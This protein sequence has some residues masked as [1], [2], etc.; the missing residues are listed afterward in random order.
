MD[1]QEQPVPSDE[2]VL[3]LPESWL[4][5]VHPRRGGVMVAPVNPADP[6]AARRILADAADRVRALVEEEPAHPER[7]AAARRHLAG[8]PDPA[9]AAALASAAT[10]DRGDRTDACRVFVDGWA[11]EHG[12][13][14]AAR[15]ALELCRIDLTDDESLSLSG[16]RIRPSP[17]ATALGVLRRVRVL[18]VE[19]DDAVY[20]EAAE[21][22]EALRWEDDQVVQ[23][24][25][26]IAYLFPTRQDRIDELLGG[27]V[28]WGP[29]EDL[30]RCSLGRPAQLDHCRGRYYRERLPVDVLATM[31]DGLGADLAPWLVH[32]LDHERVGTETVG[33][34]F[35]A[36]ALLP[37]D[38][39]VGALLD[40][41][42]DRRARA[43]LAEA[44]RRF[45]VRTVRVLARS[46]SREAAGLL[47][48]HVRANPGLVTA[49]ADLPDDVRAAVEPIVR[50]AARSV[51]EA[52]PEEL[53]AC[54]ASPPWKR[55]VK[56]AA[57]DLAAPE[58]RI[59]W[60]A[61][62]RAEWLAADTSE[63][64][65]L[66][67]DWAELARR[68]NDFGAEKARFNVLL[69]GPEDLARPILARWN[70][71]ANH[72]DSG[73]WRKVLVARFGLD[74]HGFV[75]WLVSRN[76]QRYP[77]LILPFLSAGVAAVVSERLAGRGPGCE[78]ARAWL[79]LHGTAAV[80]YL[81]PAVLSGAVKERRA[82][83]TALRHIAGRHGVD[84]VAAACPAAPDELRTLL[85]AHPA[86]TGLV[87]PPRIG[88]WVERAGFPQVLYR[89]GERAL[90]AADVP[91]LL[92]LLALPVPY[93]TGELRATFEPA[94]IAEL[95]W[96]AFTHWN[97][98]GRPSKEKWALTQL[99]SSGDDE[100][101]RR[102][103]P[104]IRAWPGEGGHRYAVTGLD[105]LAAIGSDVALMHLHSI[106]QKVKFKG[107]RARA[108]EKIAEVAEA[109]G[110]SLDELA[111]RLVP[112]FGLAADGSMTLD[113]GP[114]RFTVGFDEQLKPFVVAESGKLRKALPKPG[115]KDDPELAPAA[116][117][118]FA[119]LKKDVRAVAADQLR[120]LER[121]MATSRRWTPDEFRT[122]LVAHPLVGRVTR[123]LVW[124]AEDDGGAAAFR[125]AE[126]GTFADVDDETFVLP[127]TVR[128][129]IAH[130]LHLGDSLGAW[131]EV[132]ADY[133]LLQPFEQ[134]ARP[135]HAL[136]EEELGS[137]RLERFEGLK[138]PYGTALGL[139]KRGWERAE[140]GEAGSQ[141]YMSRRVAA[142]RYVVIDL[143][144][145][146]S[147]GDP[148]ATGDVQ[149][150]EYVRL[151]AEPGMFRWSR[152]AGHP[153]GELDPVTASEIV[154]DLTVLRDAAL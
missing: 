152:S 60:P 153:F 148:G 149:T 36:L 38:E 138:V 29:L 128:V 10:R 12:P 118:A 56:P 17:D 69:Y 45:P 27:D 121:A 81:A 64:E 39:A 134:L 2:D 34:V 145:G 94:S 86:Q 154:A 24:S 31:M 130:P 141:E 146:F 127:E 91:R 116:Y 16:K 84:A 68:A 51:P 87:K 99:G 140:P 62:M 103:A 80:E 50:A 96:S 41:S 115:A 53:P 33:R 75:S 28:T 132:F 82:A 144:P 14:F 26:M 109:R 54:M 42:A 7:A 90:P 122:H 88:D 40:R 65:R 3:R 9:G 76:L 136:T 107:L 15:A 79:D 112:R 35:D 47:E 100:A 123:R 143:D 43:A 117:K 108:Q 67:P 83:E 126:D 85:A 32:V 110:L 21:R 135:V 72:Y 73:E 70:G 61:G 11:A 59:V 1:D 46:G 13:V 111:D 150:V 147:V 125:V 78:A 8:E 142:D 74:A 120:R 104:L 133:E 131:T 55:P 89:G 63:I 19:A 137:G 98:L 44:M 4:R 124:I 113:Y 48:R 71:H 93:G 114:R 5:E 101:V 97:D 49:L 92:E 57:R 129:G 52:S 151:A 22:L 119:A 20:A 6:A 106:S 30:K 18:L 58:P 23:A 105:V 66:D 102:L 25:W 77:E 37:S 139:E 95:G